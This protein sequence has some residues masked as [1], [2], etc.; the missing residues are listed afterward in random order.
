[1]SGWDVDITLECIEEQPEGEMSPDWFWGY[2]QGRG[3]AFICDENYAL[4]HYS[5]LPKR[6]HIRDFRNDIYRSIGGFARRFKLLKRG[7]SLDDRLFFE[8]RWGYF[9]WQNREY[10]EEGL[11]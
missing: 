9:F 5:S 1:M 7:K 10:K 3:W 11:W 8:F 4:Q 6:F 2:L